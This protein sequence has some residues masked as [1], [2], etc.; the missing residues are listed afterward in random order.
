VPNVFGSR[1]LLQGRPPIP[2]HRE[3]TMESVA[4]YRPAFEGAATIRNA[5]IVETLPAA[6]PRMCLYCDVRLTPPY[7]ILGARRVC[8]RRACMEAGFRGRPSSWLAVGDQA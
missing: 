2:M 6:S 5:G 7:L 3:S 4:T 1:W 8:P